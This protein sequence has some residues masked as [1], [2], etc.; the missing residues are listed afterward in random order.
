MLRDS[1]EC[2]MCLPQVEINMSR[3]PKHQRVPLFSVAVTEV[4]SPF[5]PART[6]HFLGLNQRCPM[7]A[8]C[9]LSPNKGM[10]VG[11][12]PTRCPCGGMSNQFFCVACRYLCRDEI[13]C[14]EWR[15]AN[16][17]GGIAQSCRISRGTKIQAG[18]KDLSSQ[19]VGGLYS[20][21]CFLLIPS[22]K[23]QRQMSQMSRIGFESSHKDGNERNFRRAVGTVLLHCFFKRQC[24]KPTLLKPSGH[25]PHLL[26]LPSPIFSY[27]AA[28]DDL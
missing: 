1:Q 11:S 27:L 24:G 9:S 18:Q 13:H 10:E 3:P 16:G 23:G 20:W 26:L 12:Q 28:A 4:R 7:A 25:S 6:Q 17:N 5:F 19:G 22:H 14:C 8:H 15:N 21:C 2:Q